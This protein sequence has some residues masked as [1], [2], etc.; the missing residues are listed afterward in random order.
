MLDLNPNHVNIRQMIALNADV[1]ALSNDRV[2]GFRQFRRRS[3]VTWPSP[4]KTHA[5]IRKGIYSRIYPAISTT[6]LVGCAKKYLSVTSNETLS[7]KNMS[8][9]PARAAA[10]L[11]M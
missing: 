2:L 4:L 3:M 9:S 8:M 7:I 1:M 6:Q 10:M 5:A 11:M